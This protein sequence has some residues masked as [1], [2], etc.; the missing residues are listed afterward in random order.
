MARPGLKPSIASRFEGDQVVRDG[1]CLP[2][3]ALRLFLFG[4]GETEAEVLSDLPEA[5]RSASG[6]G[7]G[8]ER[9]SG[10]SFSCLLLFF[11]GRGVLEATAVTGCDTGSS[12][13]V[14]L[15]SVS[16]PKARAAQAALQGQVASPFTP[17]FSAVLLLVVACGP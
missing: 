2:L 4:C 3:S 8:S 9:S 14:L 7:L 13:E 1:V 11:W 17:L 15:A 5:L 12:T 6:L 16:L 10:A